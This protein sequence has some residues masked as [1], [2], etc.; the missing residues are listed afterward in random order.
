MYPIY[1][2][3]IPYINRIS[4]CIYINDAS[5]QS[6]TYEYIYILYVKQYM[7]INSILQAS[8]LQG[9]PRKR[10]LAEKISPIRWPIDAL[11]ADTSK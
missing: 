7:S 11:H 2:A 8:G 9:I 5:H 10:A 4:I 1:Q 3:Y 6:T